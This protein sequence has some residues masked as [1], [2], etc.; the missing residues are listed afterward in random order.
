ML[1]IRTHTDI[2]R[3]KKRYKRMHD[4]TYTVPFFFIGNKMRD[5]IHRNFIEGGRPNRWVPRKKSYPWPIL[6]KTNSLAMAHTVELIENGVSVVNRK[7]YQAVHNFGYPPR[8]I[9]E[10]RYMLFQDGEVKEYTEIV[11]NHILS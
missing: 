1:N 7:P 5:S 4:N 11:T 2:T 8:N 9:P 10:R 3:A 6:R